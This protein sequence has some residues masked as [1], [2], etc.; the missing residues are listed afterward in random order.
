MEKNIIINSSKIV[1]KVGTST[2]THPSGNL[3]FRHLEKLCKVL[4]DLQNSGKEVILVTSGAI[5]VGLGR[6]G[7]K[8]RPEETSKKQ[9]L[10]AVGQC[11][12]M[13]M[14]DKFF[15]E[16]NQTVAQVLLT[17]DVIDNEKGRTNVQN[18]FTE[19]LDMGIIP[20]VNENDTVATDELEGKNFGDNDTL[21]AIVA[22]IIDADLLVILTDIDGLYDKDPR[23]NKDAKRIDFVPVIDE[24]IVS[25][26]GGAGSRLGTG[27]MTTK[28]EAAK[29]STDAGIPCCVISGIDPA[30]LYDLF[31]GKDIGTIFGIRR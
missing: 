14:Y 11:E 1:V 27:G 7:F 28:I 24:H 25:L 31:D 30:N 22:K 16:Y 5:G 17:A 9:A 21:S 20:I 13:F 18:T 26:A 10:A 4:S 15:S 8:T 2:I 3:D 19:L 6:L 12:L 29:I 23:K